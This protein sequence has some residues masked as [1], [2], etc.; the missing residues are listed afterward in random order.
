MPNLTPWYTNFL[1]NFCNLQCHFV[2]SIY[3]ANMNEKDLSMA[4]SNQQ[5][6]MYDLS[7]IYTVF[8][9]INSPGCEIFSGVSFIWHTKKHFQESSNWVSWSQHISYQVTL[10][11]TSWNNLKKYTC[12][13][14]LGAKSQEGFFCFCFL[15]GEV[16]LLEEMWYDSLIN[17]T[18]MWLKMS[19]IY[20]SLRW[21][22]IGSCW[23]LKVLSLTGESN[24]IF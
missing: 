14:V 6:C 19:P 22:T 5:I 12:Y 4:F 13:K 18:K 10:L 21:F 2:Y 8:L 23:N 16:H 11:K 1:S 9:L 20:I 24:F 17:N 7:I 15:L 3:H